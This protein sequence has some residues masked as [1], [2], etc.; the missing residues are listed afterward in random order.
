MN[1]SS[2]NSV[3]GSLQQVARPNP[4]QQSSATDGP[5]SRPHA[6]HHHARKAAEASDVPG[7]VDSDGD[8]DVAARITSFADRINA[9]LQ[10]AISGTNLTVDQ[11]SALKDAAAKFEALMNRISNAGQTDVT[12]RD[13]HYALSQL[14]Q[15]IVQ[16]FHPQGSEQPGGSSTG[17]AGGSDIAAAITAPPVDTVA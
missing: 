2:L 14:H 6:T 8:Q 10:N 16:I 1:I 9:R 17:L 3:A 11:A 15:Q 7:A 5:G 4:T 12:Q 13:V